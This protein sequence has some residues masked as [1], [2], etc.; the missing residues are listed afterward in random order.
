V[1]SARADRPALSA[2]V[3]CDGLHAQES[4]RADRSSSPKRAVSSIPNL[5]LESAGFVEMR[6]AP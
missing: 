2:R 4:S 6:R 1:A 5:S 3:W